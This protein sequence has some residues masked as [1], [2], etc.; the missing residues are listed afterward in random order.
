MHLAFVHGLERLEI[1]DSCHIFRAVTF[2]CLGIIANAPVAAMLQIFALTV[3]LLVNAAAGH[4]LALTGW[5]LVWQPHAL[6]CQLF[7]AG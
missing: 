3:Q 1:A 6:V 5:D 7:A 4:V 2:D